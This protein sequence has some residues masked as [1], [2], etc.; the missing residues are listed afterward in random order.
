LLRLRLRRN[1]V[2]V[3]VRRRLDV[4]ARQQRPEL[5]DRRLGVPSL[6]TGADLGVR[7]VALGLR[8]RLIGHRL[9]ETSSHSSN[10]ARER[11]G[12]VVGVAAASRLRAATPALERAALARA[13]APRSRACIRLSRLVL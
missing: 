3:D 13:V 6:P 12:A 10:P 4:E 8:A 2:E 7:F 9:L 5:G 1:S 11:N